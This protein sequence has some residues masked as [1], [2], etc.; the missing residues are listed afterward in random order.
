MANSLIPYS[1][2]PGTK[3]MASE[4]NANFIALANSVEEGKQFTNKA[5][6]NFNTEF[7]TR[8]DEFDG[9][10]GDKLE[11]NMSNSVNVSNCI[12]EVPQNIKVEFN[13][14]TVTLKAGSVVTVPDGF[15]ED[16]V[17]AKFTYHTVENDVSVSTS[18]VG[19]SYED[20]F[21]C[22]NVTTGDFGTLRAMS[23][24]GVSGNTFTPPGSGFAFWFDR[25]SN[26]VKYVS[27]G[28]VQSGKYSLPLFTLR[29]SAA[30]LLGIN[31][32]FNGIGYIGQTTW[33]EKGVKCLFADGRN[34]DGTF[35]NISVTQ[36]A[37]T[38]TDLYNQTSQIGQIIYSQTTKRIR[39]YG[40]GPT[41]YFIQDKVPTGFGQYALW[42]NSRENIFYATA[43]SGSNWVKDYRIILP[44]LTKA[45]ENGNISGL[46]EIHSLSIWAQAYITKSYVNGTSGYIVYSNGFCEQWGR[47]GASAQTVS[48]LIPHRDVNFSVVASSRGGAA[49]HTAGN[50]SVN[51]VSNGSITVIN[52]TNDYNSAF[53]QTKGY[54]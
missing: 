12:V 35:K 42:Y 24:E 7:E 36:P 49:T 16:G 15:E 9:K 14:G 50:P 10:V 37:I 39:V 33:L 5:I 27:G 31:Q 45:S 51:I 47:T 44:K 1:F 22:Y 41:T 2:V 13:N 28:A 46:S 4:V 52:N 38:L 11:F 30:N 25:A 53:W 26:L 43:D 19:G 32:V 20:L 23:T 48:L 21:T 6:E 40:Y 54:I 34:S 8:L 17:T 3:A 18:G 29:N